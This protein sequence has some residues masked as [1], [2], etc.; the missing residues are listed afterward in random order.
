MVEEKDMCSSL[1]VRTSEF[2]PAVEQPSMEGCWNPPK[3]HNPHP[4]TE[5]KSQQD[6]RRGAIMIK[7]KS[8]LAG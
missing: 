4:K 6:D 5:K 2:Q 7:S 8:R 1:P 3:R